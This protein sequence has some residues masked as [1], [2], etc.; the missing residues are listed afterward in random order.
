M[1]LDVNHDVSQPVFADHALML[2]IDQNHHQPQTLPV[3]SSD[4]QSEVPR[5]SSPVDTAKAKG[6]MA[7]SVTDLEVT[8]AMNGSRRQT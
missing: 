8:N 6:E 5:P 1:S 7:T 4:R 2:P 3:S